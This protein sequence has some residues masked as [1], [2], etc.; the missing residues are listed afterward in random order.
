MAARIEDGWLVVDCEA[1]LSSK[2]E[3]Q[4]GDGKPRVAF[5]GSGTALV[6]PEPGTSGKPRVQLLV[7]GVVARTSTLN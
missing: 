2:V 5:R 7:D 1:P 4:V 3:I 6:R